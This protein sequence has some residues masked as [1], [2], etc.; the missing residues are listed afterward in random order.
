[1]EVGGTGGTVKMQKMIM[2]YCLVHQV[3]GPIINFLLVTTTCL[4]H[5]LA[6][7]LQGG[8]G[9]WKEEQEEAQE[10]ITSNHTSSCVRER[11]RQ[12]LLLGWI[13]TY[14]KQ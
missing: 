5:H 4:R 12:G 6:N 11:E 3:H 10:G 7:V 14:S 8:E 9:H 13:Y 2:I 1:M